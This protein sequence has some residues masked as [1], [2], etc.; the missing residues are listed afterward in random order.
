MVL[1]KKE[2]GRLSVGVFLL[3]AISIAFGLQFREPWLWMDEV[4]SYVLLS[5]PSL[6][7]VNDAIM[8]GMD[9][10][11]PLFCNVYWFFGHYIS[12][13]PLFLRVLGVVLF[14]G[15]IAGFFW[16]TTRL[17]GNGVINFLLI[18]VMVYMTHQNFV[19]A[20]GIRSYAIFLPISCA[21]FIILHQLINNPGSV[22]LLIAHVIVGLLMAFCHNYGA[23]YLAVSGA[24]FL[25]LLLWSGQRNYWFVL[26][27]F[28]VIAM[29]WLVAWYPS[30]V[31]QSDA[32]KPHSWIPLPTV[33]S[34]F[35]NFGDLIPG[36]PIKL[37]WFLPSLWFD[38]LRVMLVV[39]LYLYVAIRGLKGG[40][41]AVRQ[42]EA[43]KFFLLSG[44]IYLTVLLIALTVSLTYTSIFISRY[45]WPSQLLIM[46]QL[47]YAYYFFTG[48]PQSVFRLA[49]LLPVYALLLGGVIFYKV[50]KMESSFRSSIL[51]YLPRQN[52]DY[53][54]FVERADYFLPIWFHKQRP[55]VSFLLD[56]KNAT[57]P[58]NI[59]SA[60]T[61]YKILASLREKYNIKGLVLADTFNAANFPHFYVVD[62]Q[63]I[64]QI[65]DYIKRGRVEVIRELPIAIP[66]HRL[67]ECTFQKRK[68]NY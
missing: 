26:A 47:V 23:L 55:N 46:F 13:N 43:F 9:A 44:F 25:I 7:H 17:I 60:T 1:N 2:T 30:F 35:S 53:P 5:D 14:A 65:E 29:V 33:N 64:Y 6:A 40:F 50:W 38:V 11:P 32:G 3:L 58:N 48:Q 18:T 41:Q 19:H 54:V 10:N 12:L 51:T 45:M 34:F 24:A 20:T 21:Y 15:T 66:G 4:L 61:D 68:K 52:A 39:G 8:S 59:R 57:Q 36:V 37:K 62:E 16:Y 56:W 67:L 63:A 31:I 27:T 22:R 42:D 49:R 28:G